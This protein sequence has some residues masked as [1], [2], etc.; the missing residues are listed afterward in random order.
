MKPSKVPAAGGHIWG[1]QPRDND[2][3]ITKGTHF[4]ESM[5]KN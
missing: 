1:P 3:G 4:A 2:G 5:N